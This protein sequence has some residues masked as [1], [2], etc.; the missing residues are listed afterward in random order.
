MND[1]LSNKIHPWRPCPFGQHYVK[2]HTVHYPPSKKHPNGHSALRLAHCAKN[3]IRKSKKKVK[4]V[5]DIIAFPDIEYMT[6]LIL[7]TYRDKKLTIIKDFPNSDM[8]DSLIIGWVQYWNDIFKP[9]ELL[10]PNL[11][12][13]LMATE[14][15]FRKNPL[16]LRSAGKKEGYARGLL[17][18]TDSTVKTLKNY[19]GELTDYLLDLNTQ[20]VLIPSANICAGVRWLFQKK[21]LATHRLKREVSWIEAVAEYKSYL[22][23][24]ISGKNLNPT[25]MDNIMKYY[26]QP[27]TTE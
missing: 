12:K 25:G 7:E 21:K 17:Q 11:V 1:S 15:G 10:D 2:T 4:K 19:N 16:P 26:S 23:D 27:E 3:P 5:K 18:I 14:S 20:Q 9:T 6:K 8:Y 13:A 22:R 24:I